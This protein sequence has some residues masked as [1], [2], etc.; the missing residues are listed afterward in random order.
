MGPRRREPGRTRVVQRVVEV[1]RTVAGC[2]HHDHAAHDRK[3]DGIEVIGP[4]LDRDESALALRRTEVEAWPRPAR[5]AQALIALFRQLRRL[6]GSAGTA[7]NRKS[8]G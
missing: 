3:A 7:G 2:G 8:G 4:P 6:P 5:L 1:F